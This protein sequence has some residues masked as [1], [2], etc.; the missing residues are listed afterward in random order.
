MLPLFLLFLFYSNII[1]SVTLFRLIGTFIKRRCDVCFLFIIATMFSFF[2]FLLLVLFLLFNH[3][4]FFFL[5]R[6]FVDFRNAFISQPSGY[7]VSFLT[8]DTV[9]LSFLFLILCFSFHL[10][11]FLL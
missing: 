4:L 2:G 1:I 8:F 9:L 3:G 5:Q 7:F 11:L 6:T 10:R